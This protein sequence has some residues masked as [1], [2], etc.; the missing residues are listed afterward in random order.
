MPFKP[1]AKLHGLSAGGIVLVYAAFAGLWIAI[2]DNLLGLLIQNPDLSQ[3]IGSG[4]GFIFIAVTAALLYLL[5]QSRARTRNTAGGN[6]ARA[7][8]RPSRLRLSAISAALGMVVPLIGLGIIYLHGPHI[9]QTAYEDL[10]AIASLKAHQMEFWLNER[11]GDA[12]LIAS[13][14]GF[15]ENIAAMLRGNPDAHRYVLA[16]LDKLKHLFGYEVD[17]YD[18]AGRMAFST[19]PHDAPIDAMLGPY[20]VD[21]LRSGQVQ[22]SD[23]YRDEAGRTHLELVVPLIP[24]TAGNRR[25]PVGNLVLHTPI[26]DFLSPLITTW[27]TSSASA[28]TLLAYREGGSFRLLGETHHPPALRRSRASIEAGPGDQGSLEAEDYRGVDVLAVVQPVTGTPWSIIAKIDR[29]EVMGPLRALAFWVSVVTLFAIACLGAAIFILWRQQ[30]R[31]HALEL[32]A[33]AAEKDRVLRH[34]YDLSLIGMAI[35]SPTDGRTLHVNDELCKI[36]GYNREEMIRLPWWELLHPDQRA[37]DLA[38]HARLLSGE[39]SSCARDSRLIRKDGVVIEIAINSQCVRGPD[40]RAELTICT[41]Q[42]VTERKA[43]ERALRE[44]ESSLNRAQRIARIGSWTLDGRNNRVIWSEETYRIFALPS[45]TPPSYRLFMDHVHPDDRARVEHA[46]ETALQGAPYDI[47]YRIVAAGQTK[48]LRERAELSFDT[49][50]AL[51]S[52]I[53]TSQD[54]TKR[55]EIELRLRESEEIRRQSQR[56]AAL[57]HYVFDIES[58]SWT[59]SDMLD[60]VFGIDEG[61]PKTV[62][63]WISLIHPEQRDEMLNYLQDHVLRDRNP[64]NR[65]YRIVR[66]DDGAERWLHGLGRLELNPDG[67]PRRM[68]G[69]IQDITERRK[70]EE[71]LRLAAAVFDNSHEGVMVTNAQ[72][73]IVLVNRAFCA[74]KGYDERELLGQTPEILHSGRHDGEF[75]ASMRETLET[76]GH[77]QGEAWNRHRNG[78]LSPVLV[79]VSNIYDNEGRITHT[80]G[81]YTDISMQKSTEARLE[82]MAHHDSLTQLPNRLLMHSRLEHSIEVSRREGRRLA[83]L[84]LDLDQ[85][86]DVNDSFGHLAGDELLQQVSKRL[87]DRL[88]GVDTVARLGGDEFAVLLDN[89]SHQ[90]DALRVAN[91]IIALLSE[92]W[93]LSN[94]IEVRIGVSIGISLYPE[95]GQSADALLQQA[96]ASL[97]RAKGEGRGCARFFSDDMTEAARNR[98][99]IESKLRRAL[100]RNELQ[101]HYQPQIDMSDGRISGAEALLR[102]RDPE[103]GMIPPSVFIPVAEETGLISEI[104]AW[105]LRETCRQGRAWIDAGLPPLTLSVNLSPH[106]L[107]FNDIQSTVKQALSGSGFPPERLELELTESAL[108]AREG[109]AVAKLECLRELGVRLAIDDFGTGYS[110]LAYLK[111]F[112]I[113]VLKIDKSFIDDIPHQEDDKAITSAIVAMA[114]TLGFEVTAEGVETQEQLAFL[115]TQGCDRYQGYLVSPALPAEEFATLLRGGSRR[116]SRAG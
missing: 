57:G 2:T 98:L 81:V 83:L 88:R 43:M 108:M 24:D 102:W 33:Q 32:Q 77:W 73:R 78:E 90:E 92:P 97:Y 27:P 68:L 47:E 5:L 16:R 104:G 58:G 106:Q 112:P 52:G 26:E 67:S 44:S 114:H 22:Y 48:W 7:D 14:S 110:S 85:F 95:H 17:I 91:D 66:P 100:L 53:G 3:K 89:P 62:E 69:T 82:Y 54:I 109:E 35:T 42:D 41:I 93:H 49:D 76:T 15:M 20:L 94:G 39:I 34:F 80:V 61:Y 59:S 36:T 37:A 12:E 75:Y 87:G 96:D 56:I 103:R 10:H 74:L 11:R 28:E 4:K 23:L 115:R 116:D 9:R 107:R 45:G 13:S 29:D 46:W 64:F 71:R 72:Q 65:E 51:I 60:E 113:D 31:T 40:G 30:E 25:R 19:H 63:T 6:D 79:N 18:D 21:A 38:E 101:I 8:S 70:N 111:H 50:G 99:E 84:M 1:S 55:K 86:K 105:V